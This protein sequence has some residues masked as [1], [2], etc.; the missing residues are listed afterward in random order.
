MIAHVI[1]GLSVP[2]TTTVAAILWARLVS[3]G[4]ARVPE[5]DEIERRSDVRT[6]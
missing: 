1:I 6:W 2:F 3:K 5:L 4:M